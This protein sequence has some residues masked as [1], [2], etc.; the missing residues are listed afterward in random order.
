VLSSSELK[1]EL[2]S[3]ALA[4][5]CSEGSRIYQP[6]GKNVIVVVVV[7]V[8][9]IESQWEHHSLNMLY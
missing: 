5:C 3:E 2:S 4:F 7:V 1:S 8:V 6:V 9:V